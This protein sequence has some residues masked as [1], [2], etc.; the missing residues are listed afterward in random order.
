[1]AGFLFDVPAELET[2]G[3]ENFSGKVVF[4]ARNEALVQRCS[5][6]RSR[7]RGF[8]GGEHGPAAFAGIGDA[9]GEAFELRLFEKRDGGEVEEPGSDD[10]AA[11]PDFGDVREIEIVLIVLGIAERRSFRVSFAMGFARVGVLQNVETFGVG[12][13]QAVFDAVV[14]HL[15]EMAAAR[16]AAVEITFFGGAGCLFAAGSA[17]DVA[18]AGGERFENWIEVL[19]DFFFAANHLAVTA[20]EA[21]DAA[22]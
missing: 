13:H 4:A 1:M 8:D 6:N 18:A 12:G 5:E 17:R 20:V 19:D 22:T 3:G 7:R 10:A 16:W 15:Y 2:H 21:P 9:A 14:N 11:T